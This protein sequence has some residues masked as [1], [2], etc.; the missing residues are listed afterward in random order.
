MSRLL[1]VVLMLGWFIPN[2]A[3]NATSIMPFPQKWEPGSELLELRST[4]VSH[5][6]VE[7][8]S[9]NNIFALNQLILFWEANQALRLTPGTKGKSD[10]LVGKLG[11]YD[12]LDE[13]FPA[14]DIERVGE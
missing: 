6:F 12:K 9:P 5:Y 11:L 7:K 1:F 8:P 3:G 10:L 13:V 2:L 14:E 4:D